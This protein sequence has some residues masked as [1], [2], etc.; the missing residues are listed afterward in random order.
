LTDADGRPLQ[1]L[2]SAGNENERP[3]LLPLL[4]GLPD[5]VWAALKA[6]SA[7]CQLYAD[8][9]YDSLQLCEQITARG[10][11]PRISR[12]QFHRKG[13]PQPKPKRRDPLGRKRWPIERTNGWLMSWRR[14]ETRWEQRGDLYLGIVQLVLIVLLLRF[15]LA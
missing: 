3:Y 12:R 7:P 15:D 10:L 8:R 13:D 11:T 1:A 14:V 2:V 6:R 5:A 9:G 4:D